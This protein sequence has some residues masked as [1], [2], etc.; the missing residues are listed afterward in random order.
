MK[1]VTCGCL[2][3]VFA[4]TLAVP[5]IAQESKSAPLA[6]EL[7]AALQAAKLESIAAKD[8][9]SVDVYV[10][11]LYIPGFQ[12]LVVSGAYAQPVLLDTRL[13]KKEYRDVYIDL[14]GASAP[15]TRLLV[16]DLGADGL[17]AKREDDEAFDSVDTGGTRTMFDSDWKKQK[18]SEDEYM[19]TFAM[20]DERYSAMLTALLAQIKKGS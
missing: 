1:A 12:L 19:K 9:S 18:L 14:N 10:G 8:P 5:A 11:A 20:S 2:V 13:S 16:E 3:A 15:A 7:V 6:K 4:G 17:K